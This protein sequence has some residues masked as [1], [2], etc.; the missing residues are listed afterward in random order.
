MG[1]GEV[2]L[3]LLA[4]DPGFVFQG[5]EKMFGGQGDVEWY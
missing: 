5:L 1:L 2:A 4:L 3:G